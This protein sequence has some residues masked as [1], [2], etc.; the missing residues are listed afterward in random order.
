[1][2]SIL[3]IWPSRAELSRDI[4][5]P[6]TNVSHWWRVGEFPAAFDLRIIAA[7][8]ARG[9]TVTL[10]QIAKARE[11]LWWEKQSEKKKNG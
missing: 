7:A 9:E 6:Y 11:A 3:K 5:I 4:D 8:E 10:E 2:K 1:M